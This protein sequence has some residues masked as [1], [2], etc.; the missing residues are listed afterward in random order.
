[1]GAGLGSRVSSSAAANKAAADSAAAK[2]KAAVA[3][4]QSAAI[5]KQLADFKAA[6]R[7]KNGRDPHVDEEMAQHVGDSVLTEA[8]KNMKITA[9]AETTGVKQGNLKPSKLADADGPP[10]AT[11][12]G[13]QLNDEMTQ[14]AAA[15]PGKIQ[16]RDHAGANAERNEVVMFADFRVFIMGVEVT[17][18]VVE[19]LN[20]TKALNGTENQCSFTLDNTNDRF[21]MRAENFAGLRGKDKSGKPK[22][23]GG[24]SYNQSLDPERLPE[25][26]LDFNS[27][28][29][30]DDDLSKMVWIT[31]VK[32]SQNG[33]FEYDES[34]KADL[35]NY[36]APLYVTFGRDEAPASGSTSSAPAATTTPNAVV[37]KATPGVNGFSQAL[38]TMI[39]AGKIEYGEEQRNAE[40][41]ADLARVHGK[42]S[43]DVQQ[44][45]VDSAGN[46]VH[47]VPNPDSALV[48]PPL[49]EKLNGQPWYNLDVGSCVVS[50]HDEVRI[51]V[52][53]PNHDPVSDNVRRWMPLFTGV[54][55]SVPVRHSRTDGT[56][57]LSISCADVRYLLKKMRVT[58][59]IQARNQVPT[60]IRFDD[61]VGIFQ[62]AAFFVTS[63]SENSFESLASKLSYRQL[64]RGLLC[65][66]NPEDIL[67]TDHENLAS[68]KC[69]YNSLSLGAI[70]SSADPWMSKLDRR[71]IDTTKYVRV[72]GVGNFS[73]GW[74]QQNA[75][76]TQGDWKSRVATME[77]WQDVVT[78]GAKLDWY[79][80]SEVTTIGCGTRPQSAPDVMSP[81]SVLN[82]FVHYLYPHGEYDPS[83][84]N[85]SALGIR[86]LIERAIVTPGSDVSWSNRLEMLTQVSDV[87]DYK[88]F[89]NGMGDICFEF[90]MYDFTPNYFGRYA[91]TMAF[92][93]SI[94]S[95]EHNDEGDGNVV[96]ALKVVGGYKDIEKSSDKA[97]SN[98]VVQE[99]VYSVWIKS[100][101][102]AG[103]YGIVCEEYQ[104]PW[105]LNTWRMRDGKNDS[106]ALHKNT[107]ISFGII[108]FYKRIVAMSSMSA[109]ICY[110][111]FAC[112]NR[113]FLNKL[114]RRMGVS[115][116]V[117]ITLN[118]DST[119]STS[120]T[121]NFVRRAKQS[122]DS[123]QRF[124][125]ITGYANTPFGYVSD[126]LK[127]FTEEALENL[128]H[129]FGFEVIDPKTSKYSDALKSGMFNGKP[130]SW[131]GQSNTPV[132][133]NASDFLHRY[134]PVAQAVADKY[135]IPVSVVLAQ[136]VL[137][138]GWTGKS[139][140]GNNMFN[141][142][143]SKHWKGSTVE[144]SRATEYDANG[145]LYTAG[146]KFRAYASVE[147][148][149]DDYGKFLTSNGKY[150]EAFNH[151]NDPKAFG[152]VIAQNYGGKNN[153]TYNTRLQA[154]ISSVQ[155]K[156]NTMSHDPSAPT[157]VQAV[158]STLPNSP[159]IAPVGIQPPVRSLNDSM[160]FAVSTAKTYGQ[161]IEPASKPP[162]ILGDSAASIVSGVT[163]VNIPKPSQAT[164]VDTNP[165]ILPSSALS[166]GWNTSASVAHPSVVD[167]P[168]PLKPGLGTMWNDSNSPLGKAKKAILDPDQ[169][170]NLDAPPGQ[171][172]SERVQH[173]FDRKIELPTAMVG[174]FG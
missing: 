15:K 110:N 122:D 93:D 117:N 142:R 66:D 31:D 7:A 172:V 128:R 119:L 136:A 87:I 23:P 73:L 65:G 5:A 52:A 67:A 115:D 70:G 38:N 4:A 69:T 36:K 171:P 72:S 2:S 112:P 17:N 68:K 13:S 83:G 16:Y 48:K 59:N 164:T 3:T 26:G 33:T 92:S 44:P 169:K 125:T 138:N 39:L 30:T 45:E 130:K 139:I 43:G 153:P 95:D 152:D 53:D 166:P 25:T 161:N 88:F 100:D 162:S 61:A 99:Q 96:T 91:E 168:A 64:T 160:P 123:K 55:S 137:E 147:D 1:M 102:M 109:D 85:P 32:N 62:D 146:G 126:G 111:P 133:K 58:G 20:V 24:Y 28:Q 134:L 124:Q 40:I 97:N 165:Q 98:S 106:D 84:T 75:D 135:H 163:G 90:P 74:E 29:V 60:Y 82:C 81:Y 108:E 19:S 155:S 51:F 154:V 103:K 71:H 10:M 144:I 121:A 173:V 8:A 78:F 148:S 113:P 56:T 89:V 34:A 63:G 49:T 27:R 35:Y 76:W 156:L 11:Q 141:I 116:S 77:A 120:I 101:Y 14:A 129:D 167:I 157:T 114:L 118:I 143:D 150:K 54:V 131:D 107:L 158:T 47:S 22:R 12:T 174:T 9:P 57:S 149:F 151:S 170:I 159:A 104:I 105:A 132:S 6:F 46:V 18:W 79:S 145:N 80:D 94:K 127:L 21:I 86:N 41:K 140:H 50:L 42:T 37:N